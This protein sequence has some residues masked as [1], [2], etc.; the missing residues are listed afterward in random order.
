M[1]NKAE[2]KKKQQNAVI[3]SE[4]SLIFLQPQQQHVENVRIPAVVMVTSAKKENKKQN[5]ILSVGHLSA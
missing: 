1:Q 4:F 3:A 2:T 5:K